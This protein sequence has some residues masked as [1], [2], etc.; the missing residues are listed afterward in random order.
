MRDLVLFAQFK[1][2]E[3]HTRRSVTFSKV[4]GNTPPSN[5]PPWVIFKLRN[6]SQ[7]FKQKL[8]LKCKLVPC[9][10]NSDSV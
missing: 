10:G 9:K 8:K 5:Y 1:K 2:R 6:V 3:K 4:T 7:A